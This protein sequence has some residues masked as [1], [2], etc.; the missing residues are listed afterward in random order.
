MNDSR[1]RSVPWTGNTAMPSMT[2]ERFGLDPGEYAHL[3]GD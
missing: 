3:L 1:L 2:V